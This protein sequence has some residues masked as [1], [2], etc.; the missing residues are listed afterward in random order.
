M[1]NL[2]P[3]WAKLVTSATCFLMKEEAGDSAHQCRAIYIDSSIL[4]RVHDLNICFVVVGKVHGGF[5]ELL[6][7]QT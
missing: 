2:E 4:N 7:G 1:N 6:P 5:K 3:S